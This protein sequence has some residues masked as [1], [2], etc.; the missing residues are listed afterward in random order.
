MDTDIEV[1]HCDLWATVLEVAGARLDSVTAKQ[2]NSPGYPYLAELRG[3]AEQ[4]RR[5]GMIIEYANARMARR[6]GYKLILRYPFRGMEWDNEFYDLR[7]DPRET[8]NLYAHPTPEQSAK[9]SELRKSIDDFFAVYTV[10]GMSG[11]ELES[12]PQANMFSTWL[13]KPKPS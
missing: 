5:Q 8:V 13:H 12:Q 9:L 11:L 1:N 4:P 2:I 10:P 6:D 3:S 7:A